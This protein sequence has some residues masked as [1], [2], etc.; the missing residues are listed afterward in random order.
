M[1]LGCDQNRRDLKW[2]KKIKILGVHY[3]SNV[4]AQHI[5]NW[6]KKIE[7]MKRVIKQWSRR[8]LRIYGKVVIA[9]TFI[10][11]QLIY[12]MQRT[13]LPEDI[14]SE[15]NRTLFAFLWKGKHSN[16]KA[17]EKVKRKVLTQEF[18]QGGLK[19]IDMKY[20]SMPYI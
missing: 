7:N 9:K 16:K 14:L 1:W 18:G 5:D 8:N 3:R 20:C 10:I 17:F 19:M 13:G 6:T 12:I 2:V 4:S 11:S 15:I